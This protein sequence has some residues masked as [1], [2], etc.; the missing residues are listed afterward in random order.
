MNASS[1]FPTEFNDWRLTLGAST[2]FGRVGVVLLVTAAVLTV[3]FAVDPVARRG[4]AGAVS[5]CRLRVL[6][7]LACLATALQPAIE[8]RQV[9][10]LPNR[11][12]VLVD[13]SRSMEVRPPDGGPSRAER[14][15]ALLERAAPRLADWQRAG[16]EVDF[17]A[18]A[19]ACRRRPAPLARGARGRRDPHGEALGDV[20]ARYAGRD[21]G[22]VGHLRRASTRGASARAARCDARRDRGAGRAG[23]HRRPRRKAAARSVRRGGARRSVCLV[24]TPAA[25][26]RSSTDWLPDRQIEVTLERRSAHRHPQR[27]PRRSTGREDRVRLAAHPQL[28]L[29]IST[30]V[31]QGEALKGNNEQSFALKVIRDRVRVL[32]LPAGRPG[33][34]GSLRS[35][36]ARSERRSASFFILRT[37]SD[38]QPW[39]RN[40]LS[41][42]PFPTYEISMSSCGP[43]IWS[44][45]RTSTTRSTASSRSC[46][47]CATTSRAAAPS[48]WAAIYRSRA[49]HTARPRCATLPVELPPMPPAL[50]A[51][52]TL[53]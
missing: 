30:P 9:T 8:L 11:V 52:A 3:A 37:E 24:R 47:T 41:L 12:A 31:L 50:L 35:M 25:S 27:R 43:S 33:T 29:R 22:A 18:S 39:N 14:V 32:H 51:S 6:G 15:A 5:C 13:T 36:P 16:H 49:A 38:E 17:T 10:R 26:R 45:S 53:T 34:N 46:S 2:R 48:R 40:D 1:L 21:L 28:R 7:I 44:S 19:K 4:A 23:S 20:R 42:I